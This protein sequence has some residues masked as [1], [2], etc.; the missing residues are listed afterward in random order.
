[1]K[2]RNEVM[3]SQ[4]RPW[5]RITSAITIFFFFMQ[6]SV[7]V[8]ASALTDEMIEDFLNY[9]PEFTYSESNND[10]QFEAAAYVVDDAPAGIYTLDQFYE[11]LKATSPLNVPA[12]TYIP[13][14]VGDITTFIPQYQSFKKV[15]TPFVQ[16]RYVREQVK[17]LLGRSL[18]Y[19]KSSSYATESIQLNTLYNNA[20]TYA[21][22]QFDKRW[23]SVFSLKIYLFPKTWYGQSYERLMVKK[24]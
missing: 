23:V 14:A 1:M 8:F 16:V 9:D 7:S 18:I 13:I 20:Y 6:T 11:R 10:H 12:P 24:Y 4:F 21:L 17:R 3:Q 19:P 2:N 5:Q 22:Q 15:G